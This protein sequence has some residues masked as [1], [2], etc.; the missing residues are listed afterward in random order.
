MRYTVTFDED[1]GIVLDNIEDVHQL[2][3]FM[4]KVG[5]KFNVNLQFNIKGENKK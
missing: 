5:R 1:L 3:D 4:F 2:V